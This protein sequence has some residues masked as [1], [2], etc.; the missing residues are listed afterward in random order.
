[1]QFLPR[2]EIERCKWNRFVD[3]NDEAW[4]WHRSEFIDARSTWSACKDASFGIVDAQGNLLALVPLYLTKGYYY[5]N[6]NQSTIWLYS[7]GGPAT[8]GAPRSKWKRD[9]TAAIREYL[10]RLIVQLGAAYLK[11][12]ISA[13]A[14]FLRKTDGPRANPLYDFEFENS[15]GA[16]W[17]VDLTPPAEEIRRRYSELTRRW[18]K[19][20]DSRS[21]CIRE[22]EGNRDLEIYYELHLET[23][24][25]L[26]TTPEPFEFFKLIF[27][28][29]I[30]LQHARIVFLEEGGRVT[31]AHIMAIFK[32]GAYYWMNSSC[33][34]RSG[35]QNRVLVDNQI[36][37]ARDRGCVQFEAGKAFVPGDYAPLVRGTSDF[38]R[39]FGS[40]LVTSHEGRI[41]SPQAV[42]RP[43]GPRY[44][45]A[46]LL[47]AAAR[48]FD[49]PRA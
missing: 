16:T 49:S 21:L 44:L 15:S 25:R 11:A 38:K 2:A 35:Y 40:E 7:E 29:M 48:R 45:V 6:V 20:V 5:G 27:E 46:R 33:S 19:K 43:G 13:L 47:R 37:T 30:P 41:P 24:A 1:M 39:S 28:N 17:M 23:V 14:P 42:A 8:A 34:E 22:A 3:A 18:L 10:P 31:A 12:R 9:I 32:E 4:L 26:N 36:L